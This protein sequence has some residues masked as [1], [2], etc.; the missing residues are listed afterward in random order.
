V[1]VVGFTVVVVGFTV[2]VVVGFTVVVVVGFTVVVVGGSV[3]V[4]VGGAVVVAVVVG[5]IHQYHHSHTLAFAGVAIATTMQ[6]EA[7]RSVAVAR[8]RRPARRRGEP[9]GVVSGVMVGPSTALPAC[10]RQT[11]RSAYGP[12]AGS[13]ELHRCGRVLAHGAPGGGMMTAC[14]TG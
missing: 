6:A 5:A 10:L 14:P 12:R 7:S 4:V 8:A 3:V 9:E 13:S 1:V 11:V 2:V